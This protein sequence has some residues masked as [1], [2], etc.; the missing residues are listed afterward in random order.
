MFR[1]AHLLP[2]CALQV[3]QFGALQPCYRFAGAILGNIPQ[4][5][6]PRDTAVSLSGAGME[7]GDAQIQPQRRAGS[8]QRPPPASTSTVFIKNLCCR[9]SG[10]AMLAVL[11]QHKE[12]AAGAAPTCP[13]IPQSSPVA[14]SQTIWLGASTHWL[15]GYGG[16]MAKVSPTGMRESREGKKERNGLT[17]WQACTSAMSGLS[18]DI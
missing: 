5:K 14:A 4:K 8:R 18:P 16:P 2:I 3:A 7:P 11:H 9:R 12:T 6:N 10:Y 17:T 15:L 13:L 1:P